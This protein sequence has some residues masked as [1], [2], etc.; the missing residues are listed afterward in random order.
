MTVPEIERR[1]LSCAPGAFL[2]A[3]QMVRA[4]YGASGIVLECP[5]TLKQA[6]AAFYWVGRYGRI[7]PEHE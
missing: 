1:R 2:K 7:N 3:V 5:V 6:N 4:G